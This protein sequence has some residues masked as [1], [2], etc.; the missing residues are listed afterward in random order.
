MQS[1]LNQ[2]AEELWEKNDSF[3]NLIFILPGKRA[4]T[5]LKS[6][7]SKIV[8]KT[9]F[10][11]EI[12]SIES[13]VEMISG[14]SYA[15]NTQQL[16]ELYNA[17]L[18]TGNDEKESFYSFSKWGQILLQDFN[19]IDRYLVPTDK[20]FSYLSV[21]QEMNQWHLKPNKTQLIEDYLSFWNNLEELHA[22]F[23]KNLLENGLGHQGLVYKEACNNLSDYINDTKNKKHIFVGFN[24]LNKAE[25]YIIKEFLKEG[26]ADIF[27]DIDTCFLKDKIHDAGFFIR[28]YQK[29]WSYFKD[30]PLKGLSEYYCTTKNIQIT[31]VPKKVSQ[32]KY[33]GN[34]ISNL[35]KKD[36]KQIRSTA[37]ILGDETLLNPILNSIPAEINRVNI[38]MGYPLDKTP[39]AGMFTRLFDL[40]IQLDS[41]GWFY[42]NLVSFLVHPY[43][44]KIL[45]KD[46]LN[47]VARIK[48]EINKRNWIYITP[49][50]LES[51]FPESNE[52][53]KLLFSD[54]NVDPSVFLNKVIGIIELL[55]VKFQ[56][57]ENNLELEYLYK[58]Y[59]LFNE[60][61][62][63][64]AK[65]PFLKDLRALQSI[66][67]E[68]LST[69]KVNFRGEPL[70]G[71]Q[72]MGMLESRNLDFE[73]VIITSVNEGILPAG[74][75]NNSFI[76]FDI[77]REFGLPVYKEK[78]AVYTYHFYRLLQRAK[79]IYLIYNTEADVIEGGEKSR[80]ISQLLTDEN[81][82]ENIGTKI[83]VPRINSI[84]NSPV[85][86]QKDRDITNKI[87]AVLKKGLSPSSLTN[88]IKNPINFYKQ[89]I[90]KLEEALEV[91]ETIASNTFGTILHKAME[92]LYDPFL[93]S[94][95]TEGGL[96][97]QKQ[98]IRAVVEN[99]LLKIYTAED[100]SRGKNL[101][102][103]NVIMAYINSFILKEIQDIKH[104][105]IKILALE[106]ELS[107]RIDVPGIDTP[108]TLKGTLDRVDEKDGMLRILD[109]KTGSVLKSNVE[110]VL[111]D[112]IIENYDRSKAFQLLCYSFMY[113][114]INPIEKMN[115]GIISFKNLGSGPFYFSTKNSRNTS[116]K[117]FN[118]TK[119]TL[120]LF[121]E[122]LI[123]LIQEIANP[124]VPFMAKED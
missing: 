93:G 39:I 82:L 7:I 70:E 28:Q 91:E 36:P 29:E 17:Y 123:K 104:H 94:F 42:K 69:E 53:L 27:W 41:R 78:D 121:R 76:P 116:N 57:L 111:W 5:F 66:F 4:G 120:D 122:Q 15:T 34:L 102:A 19:E 67:K 46:H 100:I 118:I 109:Y 9:I 65:Y 88:Y 87:S 52:G 86:I 18:N 105:N 8:G 71:L 43:V 99:E 108:V 55:K 48:T 10:A 107:V 80:F 112:E 54:E 21:V 103:F 84:V 98:K 117:D 59:T 106:N 3:D 35:N 22:D 64:S 40:Y 58:F 75:T 95:L 96:L 89:K 16:F 110:V 90:L 47:T 114:I 79:N 6:S 60:L 14:L 25:T 50:K 33:V 124:D 119:E 85:S 26:K 62:L 49:S 92:I 81:H 97:G 101:I 74:K 44:Q 32:A 37:V 83:A 68:L 51:L 13:F 12:H 113:Q 56:L 24:A 23:S 63:L 2:I 45:T 20:L 30:H 11:P 61:K 72:I 1:F 73:T 38:T 31:G 77:K 115:A